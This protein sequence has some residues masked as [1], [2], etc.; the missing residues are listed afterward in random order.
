MT[1]ALLEYLLTVET[2]AWEASGKGDV[3]FFSSYLTEDAL[4][5]ASHG[6]FD[7]A[8]VLAALAE[9]RDRSLEVRIHGARLVHLGPDTVVLSYQA[10]VEADASTF[11]VYATTAYVRRDGVWFAAFNQLTPMG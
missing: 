11:G 9:R 7:K 4:A 5:V 6:R 3:D 2:L 1:D 8:T 10:T